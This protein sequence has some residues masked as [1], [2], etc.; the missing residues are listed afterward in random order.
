[1][2]DAG[3]AGAMPSLQDMRDI[4]LPPA[5]SLWPSTAAWA[6][7]AGLVLGV[8]GWDVVR[9]VRRWR[10]NAYR[11]EALRAVDLA[12]S[13]GD[14]SAVPALVKRAA[15]AAYPRVR[16]AGLAGLDWARFLLTTAP[17]AGFSEADAMTLAQWFYLPEVER[18]QSKG[19]VVTVAR[20]W[21]ARHD[22]AL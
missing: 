13:R 6:V 20:R 2:A 1:M 16:V 12:S 5:I 21:I 10:A 9:R 22:R 17:T 14:P 3:A 4:V 19:A 15:L 11:R 7:L 8:L 18:R